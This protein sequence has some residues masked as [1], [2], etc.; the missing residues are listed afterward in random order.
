MPIARGRVQES[1][2]GRRV[3]GEGVSEKD[4]PLRYT[5]RPARWL[6]AIHRRRIIA[7]EQSNQGPQTCL[8]KIPKVYRFLSARWVLITAVLRNR[9]ILYCTRVHAH[10][11]GRF[12]ETS[13]IE[14][15]SARM[16][17]AF[18]A[19]TTRT[20]LQHVL[21]SSSFRPEIFYRAVAMCC[22]LRTQPGKPVRGD[23]V[24]L[25][26]SRAYETCALHIPQ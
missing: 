15:R 2:K 21:V 9:L 24:Q 26:Y 16:L 25:L 5:P 11:C 1:G 18:L 3:G 10:C 17:L 6:L 23:T 20:V 8:V 14:D 4:G 13:T 22:I 19:V 12:F 7:V